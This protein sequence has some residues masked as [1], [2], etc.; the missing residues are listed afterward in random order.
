[1]R[2]R[3]VRRGA[4]AAGAAA[5]LATVACEAAQESARA[6]DVGATAPAYAATTLAGDSASLAALRGRAVLLN[7]WATWCHPCREEIPVLQA[8]H[9][10]HAGDGLEVVGVSIDVS[11]ERA[12]V[13]EFVQEFA[14]TYPVWLDPEGRVTNAFPAV[15][16]PA[17]FLIDRE[18]TVRWR[19]IGPIAENDTSLARVLDEVL[20]AG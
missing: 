5:L 2:R 8:L 4:L 16:V 18:G 6:A 15:G 17:T 10:R 11:S 1:M 7:V 3:T 19:K 13:G 20:T 12:A 9:E 14:M